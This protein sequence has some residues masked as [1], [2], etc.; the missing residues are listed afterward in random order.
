MERKSFHNS[1]FW[2][3]GGWS[4]E[5]ALGKKKPQQTTHKNQDSLLNSGCK[6]ICIDF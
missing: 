4:K 3:G 2:G 5:T 1:T 6:H